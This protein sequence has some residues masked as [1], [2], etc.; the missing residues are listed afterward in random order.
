[1]AVTGELMDSYN[2][3]G[4]REDLDDKIYMVDPIKTPFMSMIPKTKATAVLHE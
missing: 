1:M 2:V 3:I 4:G